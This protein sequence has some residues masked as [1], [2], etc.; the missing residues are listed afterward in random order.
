VHPFEHSP[1]NFFNE[2]LLLGRKAGFDDLVGIFE[3]IV[4]IDDPHKRERFIYR[5]DLNHLN[6]RY[7]DPCE[8]NQ[9]AMDGWTIAFDAGNRCTLL[10]MQ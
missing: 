5:I 4:I 2:I 8:I 3:S 7:R 1:L 6:V 10:V 9:G